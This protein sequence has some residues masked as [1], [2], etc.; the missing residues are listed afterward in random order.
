VAWV[1]LEGGDGVG[2]GGAG[3]F[4]ANHNRRKVAETLRMAAI[5][6]T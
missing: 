5:A 4:L 3:A 2:D 6:K 1:N